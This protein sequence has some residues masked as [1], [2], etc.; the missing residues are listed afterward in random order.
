MVENE[1]QILVETNGVRK[2]EV[3]L[4]SRQAKHQRS[5]QAT[6]GLSRFAGESSSQRSAGAKPS[7]RRR[8][9]PLSTMWLIFTYALQ[10]YELSFVYFVAA[11]KQCYGCA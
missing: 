2:S 10:T 5:C 4:Q 1:A 6:C 9:A 11:E 3:P 7:R 8:E